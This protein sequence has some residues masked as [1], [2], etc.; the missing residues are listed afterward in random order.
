MFSVSGAKRKKALI[1]LV[2]IIF[3]SVILFPCKVRAITLSEERDLGKKFV[4]MV[5]KAMPLVEDG[6]V[7][8][9][10]RNIGNRVAA[11]VGITTYRFQFFVV[12]ES[13]P[14]AFAVPG[15]YIFIY[16]GLIEMMSSEDELAGI[17]SHELAHIQARH[18]QRSIDEQKIASIGMVAGMIAGILLGAPGL[19]AAGMATTESMGLEYSR[20]HEMEAD[21]FGFRFLC[22]AG[23]DPGAMPSMMA[24]LLD[25]TYLQSSRVPNYLSTHPA[26]QERVQYL[27]EMVKKQK[28]SS[29]KT[30]KPASGDFKVMQATLIADYTDEAKAYDRF[31][32]GIKQGDNSAVFGLGRLYLRQNKWA[33]AVEQLREAARAMPT[34]PFVL[35]TLGEAY[36]RAGKLREAQTTLESALLM[37]PSAA[38][39]DYRLALI[40]L[41]MGKKD[42]A[43][44]HLMRIE[45]LSPMFPEVDYQLGVT[46]GQV[47]KLGPAHF[48]L[49]RYYYNKEN[50]QLAIS[51]FKKAKALYTDS[52]AKIEEIDQY[53]RELEPKRKGLFI[54][55]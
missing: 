42:E 12:D 45:E 46:L 49:G 13:I 9:Y 15:G 18:L 8:T 48:H 2:L 11:Q 4:R 25:R 36:H 34:S 3:T 30:L 7:L 24:K 20:A 16:R 29:R 55:G 14:N 23:Y 27:N 50:P 17:L 47:N 54:K 35:S 53:I 40:L 21:Q 39:A 38:I 44:E 10:V 32:A 52:P 51:H 33:Q 1:V 22:A 37:D 41:E 26:L 19:A 31:Q 6:E 43:V 5:R 28:A